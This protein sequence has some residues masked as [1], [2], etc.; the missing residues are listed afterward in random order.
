MKT[1]KKV[2]GWIIKEKRFDE[3]PSF[4]EDER[5][6]AVFAP[7]GQPFYGKWMEDNLTL[8]EATDWCNDEYL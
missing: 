1:L 2:N 8:D 4:V 5:K 6:Y 7:K 3:V